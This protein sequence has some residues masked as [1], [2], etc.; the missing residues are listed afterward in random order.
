[1]TAMRD[2][3]N[4]VLD[5][6]AAQRGLPPAVYMSNAVAALERDV[7][8]RRSWIR[9]GRADLVTTTGA[10]QALDEN[11]LALKQQQRGLT[12]ADAA[13]G[14]LHLLLQA[15]VGSSPSGMPPRW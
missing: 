11:V 4:Q 9:V 3:L 7:I 12:C 8:C 1:M 15:N 10:F 5:M 2:G 13:P 14:W 6:S